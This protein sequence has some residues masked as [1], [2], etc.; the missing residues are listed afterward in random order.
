M[1]KRRFNIPLNFDF[2][3]FVAHFP[4]KN[5]DNDI[6]AIRDKRALARQKAKER[7]Q[8]I[9][10]TPELYELYKQR[11]KEY[12]EIYNL[13]HTRPIK[14]SDELRAKRQSIITSK[15]YKRLKADIEWYERRLELARNYYKRHKERIKNYKREYRSQ[16]LDKMRAY[17]RERYARYDKQSIEYERIKAQKRAWA[18]RN[19]ERLS[20]QQAEYKRKNKERWKTTL[21]RYQRSEKGKQNR[22]RYE[23]ENAQHI[24]AKKREREERQK[25]QAE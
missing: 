17:E 20:V 6:Q 3:S 1:Q 16:N 13:L 22:R 12:R 15:R 24:L 14:L 2:E 4:D 18:R 23:K 25:E 7:Y 9:K 11:Q 19:R 10:N 8:L 5:F 21:K